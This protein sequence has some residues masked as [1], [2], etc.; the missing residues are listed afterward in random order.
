MM[1]IAMILGLVV[2]LNLCSENTH[3]KES[4]QAILTVFR[5]AFVSAGPS[6]WAHSCGFGTA[7]SRWPYPAISK[8]N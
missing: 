3:P 7:I 5:K 6:N 8:A 2:L 1:R 4:W